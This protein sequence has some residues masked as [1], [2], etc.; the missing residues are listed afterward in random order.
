MEPTNRLMSWMEAQRWVWPALFGSLA[1][2]LLVAGTML[3]QRLRHHPLSPPP[4]IAAQLA[5]QPLPA[6]SPLRDLTPDKRDQL[7][8]ILEANRGQN[9]NL[10]VAVRE[11]REDLA[12]VLAAEPF[13]Q[14][15]YVASATRLIEAEA[16]A[17]TAAQ[18]TFAQIAAVLSARERQDFLATQRQL[19]QEL[20]RQSP[21]GRNRPGG[22]VPRAP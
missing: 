5:R 20:L 6:G 17:R 12:K 18:P 14:A 21:D 11:R 7:R 16:R 9:R 13:D 3:G 15:A 19:R 8:A 1:L 2:N 4:G 22:V 10:W